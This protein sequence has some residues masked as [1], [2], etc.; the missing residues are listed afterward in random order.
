MIQTQVVFQQTQL[1]D[2]ENYP[3]QN[4]TAKSI[5]SSD[6]IMSS[7]TNS[8][9]KLLKSYDN[10][11]K[12]QFYEVVIEKIKETLTED[13]S[14]KEELSECLLK[15]IKTVI[16]N[17]NIKKTNTCASK[18]L[19]LKFTGY[20]C[21][22]ANDLFSHDKYSIVSY[23]N[24]LY[25]VAWYKEN[26]K[27]RNGDFNIEEKIN[28]ISTH[29]GKLKEVLSTFKASESKDYKSIKRN[30]SNN[31]QFKY[32]NYNTLI[33]YIVK[34]F[35]TYES[36]NKCKKPRNTSLSNALYPCEIEEIIIR[37]RKITTS[38]ECLKKRKI[39]TTA[40]QTK[41]DHATEKTQSIAHEVQ[42]DFNLYANKLIEFLI[43]QKLSKEKVKNL[44]MNFGKIL[45]IVVKTNNKTPEYKECLSS[46]L[47][48]V[49]KINA[50]E[51]SRMHVNLDDAIFL[52]KFL[53]E[54]MSE[55][56]S[57]LYPRKV[58]DFHKILDDFIDALST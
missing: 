44:V 58:Y 2:I 12:N 28:D 30:T 8:E 55:P 7:N 10:N 50:S 56:Q 19:Y 3:I 16:D 42:E 17:E 36:Y 37:K 9:D 29:L 11:M 48:I 43:N 14:N 15:F 41:A 31:N 27:R 49:K 23:I 32:L 5:D 13:I 54:F 21:T 24:F 38:T 26:S 20:Y 1:I 53:P 46:L 39:E 51:E 18:E 45:A 35:S 57:Y 6:E 22:L 47:P 4:F 40:E 52:K 33:L 25:F 34:N